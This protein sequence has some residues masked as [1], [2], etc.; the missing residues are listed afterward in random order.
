MNKVLTSLRSHHSVPG[1]SYRA[2]HQGPLCVKGL[3]VQVCMSMGS[4]S[5]SKIRIWKNGFSIIHIKET[6]GKR[7]LTL[8][9]EWTWHDTHSAEN[10]CWITHLS[11]EQCHSLHFFQPCSTRTYSKPRHKSCLLVAAVTT[12]LLSRLQR[13]RLLRDRGLSQKAMGFKGYGGKNNMLQSFL[14]TS[15]AVWFLRLP[16]PMQGVLVWYL[17]GELRSHILHS[18]K[19]QNIKQKQYGNKFNKG[20]KSGPHQKNL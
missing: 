6:M 18:Q 19:K 20:F 5:L 2:C 17:F 4:T 11:P 9:H 8:S 7:L 10:S 12:H 1:M 15:L 16:F 14:G 13:L 3:S